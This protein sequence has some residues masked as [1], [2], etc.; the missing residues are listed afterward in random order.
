MPMVCERE[1]EGMVMLSMESSSVGDISC[2]VQWP[3]LSLQF[4]WH[5]LVGCALPEPFHSFFISFSRNSL[6][7]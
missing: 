2:I 7:T 3:D 4:K 1:G 6:R 5:Q